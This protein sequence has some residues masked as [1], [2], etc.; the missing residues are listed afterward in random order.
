MALTNIDLNF[1]IVLVQRTL[2]FVYTLAKFQGVVYSSRPFSKILSII[3][4]PSITIFLKIH[5]TI[6]KI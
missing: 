5:L 4:S 3:F 2:G 1:T 6:K